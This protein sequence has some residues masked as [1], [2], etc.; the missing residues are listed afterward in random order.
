ME[1]D[2]LTLLSGIDIPAPLLKANVH[3]PT[4]REIAFMGEER[5]Y[6]SVGLFNIS[7]DVYKGQIKTK[8]PDLDEAKI[9]ELVKSALGNISDFEVFMQTVTGQPSNGEEDLKYNVELILMLLFPDCKSFIFEERFIM[10]MRHPGEPLII[11]DDSFKQ[12]KEIIDVIFCLNTVKAKEFNPVDDTAKAIAAKL[13][14][15]REKIRTLKGETL[16]KNYI[17]ANYVSCLGIGSN[18]LDINKAFSLTIYQLFNQMEKYGLKTQYDHG[19][20][21]M[22]AGAKDVELVDWLQDSQ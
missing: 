2:K 6:K 4:I 17:L 19:V 22:M 12:L 10:G 15:A 3:Q 21:A 9:D 7:V 18:S 5:F 8:L 13:E 20:S 11:N 1:I 14:K 16:K